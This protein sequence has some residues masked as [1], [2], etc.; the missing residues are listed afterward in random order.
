MFVC[1]CVSVEVGGGG[2]GGGGGAAWSLMPGNL[3]FFGNENFKFHSSDC[4]LEV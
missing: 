1:V 3:R 2:G 4:S